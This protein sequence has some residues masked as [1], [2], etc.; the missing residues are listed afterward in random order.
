[1]TGGSAHQRRPGRRAELR[2]APTLGLQSAPCSR[3]RALPSRRTLSAWPCRLP[4]HISYPP[5]PPVSQVGYTVA[6]MPRLPDPALI[7]VSVVLALAATAPAQAA[8]LADCPRTFDTAQITDAATEAE[9][10]FGVLDHPAFLAA[11]LDVGA[12]IVCTTDLLAP[13]VVAK[14]HRV[15]VL[16]AYLDEQAVRVPQALAGLFAAEPGHQIPA[17]LLPDGHPIR[18]RVASA[19]MAL[20][21]DPGVPV[22]TLTSGWV[23]ADS[24][25]TKLAP[26]QRAAVFQQV[27]GQGKVVATHYRWPEEVDFAWMAGQVTGAVSAAPAGAGS[28]ASAAKVAG[29]AGPGSR[30]VPL[31]AIS[32]ASLLASGVMF[33]L[34]AE[35]R[36]EFDATSA[37]SSAASEEERVGYKED[38]QKI[39]GRVNPLA[40][41]SYA[42][43]GVAVAL[44]VVAMVT[45]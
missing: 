2:D 17:S 18:A 10:A 36:A 45:W 20:R 19:M 8:T 41:A 16:G 35:G 22:P 43:A 9:R 44:G 29:P 15:E 23:E 25:A 11:R 6:T 27:D 21:D 31:I 14:V 5:L 42:T 28:A 32:G 33:A 7:V 1:M 4:V 37:L 3:L 30:R 26:T 24:V 40:Y 12:R 38:L 34:A 13:G 39:Q